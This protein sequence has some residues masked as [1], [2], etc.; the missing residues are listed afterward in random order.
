MVR[1]LIG[2][3]LV[4]DGLVR[5]GD[6]A[7]ALEVQSSVGGL[8]GHVLVRLGSLS[9]AD[10]LLSLSRQLELPVQVREEMPS[11][12]EVE[13]FLL[14]S[15]TSQTWWAD[16]QAVA[17]R[18]TPT[19]GDQDLEEGGAL[20][21]SSLGAPLIV[22]AVHPLDLSLRAFIEQFTSE[23]I[24]WRLAARNVVAS[25]L[26][27]IRD[28]VEAQTWGGAS[29]AARLRELAEEAPV[30]DFVNAIFAEALQKRAS[31]VHVEPFE[32]RFFVRMRVDGILHTV[33]SAPRSNF[34]AV[35][36]RLK[37]LSGMDIGERRLPQDGRQAVRISGQDIDLRVSALPASWGESLVLRLLGKT[38]R[39]P[40]L[41]ELGLPEA[42]ALRLTQLVEQPHGIVL[43]TGPT[44]SGKTTT[45]YRLLTRLN[46][47]ERKIVTV[48]DPVEF[49]L[50][51]VVQVHVRSDIG[52]TFAAGLRSI[53]R[54]DPDVIMV[55]EIRDPETA[56]IAIQAA[57]TGHMVISTV[58]TNSGLAAIARLL[59]LGVEEYLLA[60]VMRGVVG[61]RL[62]RRLCPHCSVS[63]EPT[64]I[65]GYLHGLSRVMRE[66]LATRTT[67][68]R[69]P[70][71]CARC[72]RTGFLG[73][74]GLYEI[75]P[76]SSPIAAAVRTRES[77]TSLIQI[78]R[79]EGFTSM[80]EDGVLKAAAGRT[81]MSEVYR[82]IGPVDPEA[83]S[84]SHAAHDFALAE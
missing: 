67:D 83:G 38:S 13:A 78:A 45:I 49:D 8:L 68:W 33:R 12:S 18:K 19:I 31:D 5:P 76:F 56:R 42:D 77:E 21:G 48:E 70:K 60:D 9:E 74:L 46:D 20:E 15:R 69:E 50:P 59:D 53:L 17:W 58:H 10:L 81:S 37:L 22:A 71:G 64:K 52:L 32:D 14:E 55:G 75:A 36:S 43:V 3:M 84:S 80:F 61:Q 41:T 65:S 73:R 72:G 7:A 25:A 29:D 28:G 51:G 62:I 63:S 26:D 24:E 16:R 66:R 44:G 34:D 39:I 23:E 54:Q 1:A 27:D 6:V 47:G 57:L 4:N 35:C 40:E 79:D 11:P 30:I 82:V 2:E